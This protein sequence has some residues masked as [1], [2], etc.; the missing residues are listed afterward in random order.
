MSLG[1]LDVVKFAWEI[2]GCLWVAG[3]LFTKR[4]ARSQPSAE[5][6]LQVG[7]A[8]V[9]FALIAGLGK[10][11]DWIDLRFVPDAAAFRIAGAALTIAGCAFAIW[12]R[13]TLGSNWSGRAVVKEDHEL[14]ERGPYALARHPIYSGLLL[15]LAGTALALGHVGAVIGVVVIAAVFAVKMRHE[16]RLMMETFPEAYPNYR[17]RV[18]A[19]IPGIL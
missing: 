13:V 10:W 1:A 14:I 19:V 17:R 12:A 11:G 18:K 15:A 8:L 16:E 9:G 3:M 5:R 7:I 6:S 2:T 4:T